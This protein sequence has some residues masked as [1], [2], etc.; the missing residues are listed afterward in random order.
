[1]LHNNVL[2]QLFSFFTIVSFIT[3]PSS[4]APGTAADSADIQVKGLCGPDVQI[5]HMMRLFDR[6]Q[7]GGL[8]VLWFL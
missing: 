4:V 7:G 8:T 6:R 2:L 1:M 5:V 3:P